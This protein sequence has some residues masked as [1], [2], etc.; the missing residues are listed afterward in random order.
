MC[1]ST[2]VQDYLKKQEIEFHCTVGYAPQQNGIAERKNRS[3]VAA[4]RT[5]LDDAKLP[6]CWWAEAVNTANYIQNRVF[7]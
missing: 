1:Q 4:A 3:L 2:G 6:K 5:M 7:T